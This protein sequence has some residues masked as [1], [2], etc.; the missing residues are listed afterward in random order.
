MKL[1]SLLVMA[2]ALCIIAV[3]TCLTSAAQEVPTPSRPAGD[4]SSADLVSELLAMPT[5]GQVNALDLRRYMD[6]RAAILR[7]I[8]ARGDAVA[9]LVS[10][11]LTELPDMGHRAQL[12]RDIDAVGD[13]AIA[14]ILK[15]RPGAVFQFQ[16]H[17]LATAL[18]TIKTPASTKALLALLPDSDDEFRTAAIEGLTV[19]II[20]HV[21]DSDSDQVFSALIRQAPLEK[22]EGS[23]SRI[24]MVMLYLAGK[25]APGARKTDP[26]AV[27]AVD[28][29]QGR[30]K[31][32]ESSQVRFEAACA[33]A[34]FYDFSGKEELKKAIPAMH[35]LAGPALGR[36]V[37]AIEKI[38]GKTFG[39]VPL[40]PIL[41]S[42]TR[43]IPALRDQRQALLDKL[44]EW[45]RED[46][47]TSATD[48][49]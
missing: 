44:A 47:A 24:C 37:S 4:R 27:S 39:P 31:N 12:Y 9:L 3:A 22:I 45:A 23:R 20:R 13:P 35:S 34:E 8:A 16:K 49:K 26:L 41:A 15:A 32:D 33:L 19:G 25:V 36:A 10:K 18:A 21:S 40:D 46:T 7:E 30:L 11:L 14:A 17:Q 5:D 48:G 28:M 1:Y 2:A 42:D 38:S 43:A 29:L 6:R